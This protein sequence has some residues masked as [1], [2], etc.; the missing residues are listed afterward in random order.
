MR[1]SIY[2]TVT[3][4]DSRQDP[5]REAL[6]NYCDLADE[7]I[8]VN[9]GGPLQ[10]DNSK[11]K[12]INY[13]W[14]QDWDWEE[15]TKHMNAGLEK[16]TGDWAIRMDIDNFFHES[17]FDNIRAALISPAWAKVEVVSFLAYNITTVYRANV[18]GQRPL[19]INRAAYPDIRQGRIINEFSDLCYPVRTQGQQDG[20]YFGDKAKYQV[21]GVHYLNYD[22]T[23]RDIE[24]ARACW[25]RY[26]KPFGKFCNKF[27]GLNDEQG[28]QVFLD[29]IK[30]RQSLANKELRLK[31]HPVHIRDKVKNITPDKLGYALWNLI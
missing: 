2:S 28:F 6:A 16:C 22:N 23:F 13:P 25:R 24:T 12:F 29:M 3:D 4:P 27:N 14:P 9:G 19:A 5:W 18:K 21:S 30:G 1:L 17:D 7:V 20:V 15:I 11:V 26:L 31:D 8:V 10:Y